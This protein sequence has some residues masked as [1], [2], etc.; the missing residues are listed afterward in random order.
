VTERD[1]ATTP[2]S[3]EIRTFVIGLTGGVGSGKSTVADA[4]SALGVPVIDADQLAREQV[5]PG[6]PALD[7]IVA[8]FGS[9]ILTANGNLDRDTMRQ[10]IYSDPVQKSRLESILHPRIRKRIRTLLAGIKAPY[11][12]VV[13]PLLL[14]TNQTDLVDRILVIDIPEK[15]QLK[16]VAARDGLSDNA[17]MAIM[18]AQADRKTRLEVADDVIVNDQDISALTKHVQELHEHYMDMTHEH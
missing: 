18:N 14:E 4:F 1:T 13:I 17:V 12:I 15:E 2:P 9:D 3:P 6:Q 5:A 16:R 8:G 10:R 7:E 11:T